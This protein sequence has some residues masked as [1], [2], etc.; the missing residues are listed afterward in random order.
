MFIHDCE[1]EVDQNHA[2]WVQ[3]NFNF[4]KILA[5]ESH[6]ENIIDD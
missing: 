5:G 4:L 6:M 3:L 2:L 1:G